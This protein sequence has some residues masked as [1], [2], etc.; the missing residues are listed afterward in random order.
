M[1]TLGEKL[2]KLR[3]NK[4]LTLDKLSEH[5]IQK[6]KSG[7]N[8]SIISKWEN[9]KQVPNFTSLDMY[10]DYFNVSLDYLQGNSLETQKNEYYE[11]EV[12]KEMLN[13]N[14]KQRLNAF[15]NSNSIM[16]FNSNGKE[17]LETQE[18]IEKALTDSFIKILKQKGEL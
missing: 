13:E 6:Y 4:G 2:K 7:T 1:L 16:F 5:F 9:D 11:L 14:Q 3:R 17:D 18:L 10:C 12:E 8:K 15:V